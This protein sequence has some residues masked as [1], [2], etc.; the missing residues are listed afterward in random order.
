[1]TEEER[2]EEERIDREVR[3]KAM[4]MSRYLQPTPKLWMWWLLEKTILASLIIGTLFGAMI[5]VLL[6]S[7]F[8]QV[9]FLK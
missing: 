7:A 3:E 5:L 4:L 8:I 2:R 9:I 6:V 1:M